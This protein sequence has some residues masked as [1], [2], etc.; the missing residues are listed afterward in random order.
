MRAHLRLTNDI[1][2]EGV[3][4]SIIGNRVFPFGGVFDGSGRKIL[5]FKCSYVGVD[6]IGLFRCTGGAEIKDLQLIDPNV[7]CPGG[8]RIGALV[9]WAFG[10]IKRSEVVGGSVRGSWSVAMLVGENSGP[11]VECFTGG[12]VIGSQNIGGLVGRNY[13]TVADCGAS[14]HVSGNRSVGGLVGRNDYN[15]LVKS[16]FANGVVIGKRDDVGGLVGTN[17]QNATVA[18]C[19][20]AGTVTGRNDVGGLVGRN[21]R[22]YT[23]PVKPTLVSDC[24]AWTRTEGE[25]EVGGLV[26]T[27]AG[28]VSMCYAMGKVVGESEVGGLVGHNYKGEG[29]VTGSFW[30]VHTSGQANMCGSQ[31]GEGNGC[32]DTNGKTTSEMQVGRTFAE[33]GWDFV[34]E[35]ENGTEDIWAICEGVDYPQLAW[36]YVIGD[37]DADADTDLADFCILAEHWL[38]A[39]GSFWCGHGCDLTSDGSVNSEDLAVFAENWLGNIAP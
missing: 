13:G 16:S 28:C 37:F 27:N 23:W 32:T 33:A 19:Y 24:Y 9:G 39:D 17:G 2:L 21:V 35:S 29:T 18:N 12:S 34:G 20:A 6:D 10:T 5:N 14:A 7:D 4:L 30:D 3:D 11:I 26:G 1:D 31:D 22:P 36:E 25:S 8:D 38:A 15:S